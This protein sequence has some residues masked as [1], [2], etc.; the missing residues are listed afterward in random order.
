MP[1]LETFVLVL[2]LCSATGGA[3]AQSAK[4]SPPPKSAQ[5]LP[6][7]SVS[8]HIYLDDLKAPGRMAQV[9]L[10][11]VTALER[12]ATHAPG[13]SADMEV[14]ASGVAT[15]FDGSYVFTHV[16]PGAYYVIATHPGYISPL[17]VLS[18]AGAGG[19]E[20]REKVLQSLPRVE[21]EGD[22]PA[23]G[24]DV[25]LERGGAISGNV[26]YDDGGPAFGVKVSAEIRIVKDGKEAWTSVTVGPDILSLYFTDD[27][28][29]YR[30]S[31]LPAGTYV[32]EATLT[33]S[34]VKTFELASG[35]SMAMGSNDHAASLSFYSGNTPLVRN[36]KAFTLQAQ[37]ERTGEDI[38]IPIS[39]LHTVKGWIVAARDGHVV[40]SGGVDL[41]RADDQSLIG[42]Q[43]LS[44]SDPGFAFPFVLEGEYLLRVQGAADVNYEVLP[45]SP[46]Y[47]GAPQF[48]RD[49]LHPYG[50]ASKA[51]DVDGDLDS[52]TISVPEPAP[53]QQ[54]TA[55]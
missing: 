12:D 19:R 8:G 44:E 49:V 9:S 18:I 51:L 33:I 4:D 16:A 27:R 11:P 20:A 22:Q 6:G 31:G 55:Q 23:S 37:E 25:T 2:V 46:G 7:A 5:K 14:V 34:N 24:V 43:N 28:G 38:V 54:S 21:V 36:A 47:F 30:I 32:V 48:K 39:K 52:V 50:S 3:S 10:K 1:R 15:Q 40:N 26:T 35:V 53:G 13:H 29:N 17:A 41:V 45:R 42:S